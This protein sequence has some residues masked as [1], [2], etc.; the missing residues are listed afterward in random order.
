MW[1]HDTSSE[2][3]ACEYFFSHEPI[4]GREL[5]NQY[6]HVVCS[7]ESVG[8]YV[9]ALCLDAGGGNS[10]LLQLLRIASSEVKPNVAWLPES[11]I[12]TIHPCDASRR[13]FLFPCAVHG[14]NIYI[15]ILYLS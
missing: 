1:R 9:D 4:S 7:L 3:I 6:L 2:K 13:I 8:L 10:K 15:K 11:F 12:S 14:I 5:R